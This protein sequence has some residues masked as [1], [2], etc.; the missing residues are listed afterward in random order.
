MFLVRTHITQKDTNTYI[1]THKNTHTHTH[2]H[3]HVHPHARTYTHA[4]YN[5][6]IEPRSYSSTYMYVVMI[7]ELIHILIYT[8]YIDINRFR[9]PIITNLSGHDHM[10]NIC[11]SCM[12]YYT[13]IDWFNYGIDQT[14]WPFGWSIPTG[15]LPEAVGSNGWIYMY[16]MVKPVNICFIIYFIVFIHTS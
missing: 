2:T 16:S 12:E 5:S 13:N 8:A 6:T 3:I 11:D 4:N 1:N 15:L 10:F 9:Q 14:I 7:S